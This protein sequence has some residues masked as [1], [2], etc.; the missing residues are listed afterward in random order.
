[1][2]KK[3]KHNCHPVLYIIILGAGVKIAMFSCLV[4]LIEK[5]TDN[6]QVSY[7][8]RCLAADITHCNFLNTH[9]LRLPPPGYKV[10]CCFYYLQRMASEL[11]FVMER[12]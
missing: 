10:R 7:L 5:S 8:Y 2:L 3:R 1:M 9:R 11:L 12:N 6:A 4:K